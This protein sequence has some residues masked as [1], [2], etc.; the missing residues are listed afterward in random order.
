MHTVKKE[1]KENKEPTKAIRDS[2]QRQHRQHR[3]HL[4]F[5]EASPKQHLLERNSVQTP[6]TS[7]MDMLPSLDNVFHKEITRELPY[8]L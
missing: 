4:D 2:L 3:Q 1:E 5:K 7:Q 8:S 6:L